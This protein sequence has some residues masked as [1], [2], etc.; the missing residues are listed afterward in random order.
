MRSMLSRQLQGRIRPEF[1]T[2]VPFRYNRYFMLTKR[3]LLSLYISYWT[4]IFCRCLN[5]YVS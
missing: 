4:V 1:G 3:S 2:D 5:I